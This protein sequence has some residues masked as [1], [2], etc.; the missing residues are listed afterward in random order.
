MRIWYKWWFW[1]LVLFLGFIAFSGY[2][3]YIQAEE[4]RAIEFV[5][6]WRGEDGKGPTIAEAIAAILTVAY[7]EPKYIRAKWDGAM[8]DGGWRVDLYL[9]IDGEFLSLNFWTDFKTVKALDEEAEA[10]IKFVN[11]T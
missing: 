5:K 7:G 11:S 9:I 6:N 8:S 2:L 1:L 4:E 10:T 3:Q